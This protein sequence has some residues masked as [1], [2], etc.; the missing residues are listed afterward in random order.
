MISS[1]KQND[2]ATFVRKLKKYSISYMVGDDGKKVYYVHMNDF[3]QIAKFG[4]VT[5]DLKKANK[6]LKQLKDSWK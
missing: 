6:I 2:K 1:K 4:S 3:N 5:K